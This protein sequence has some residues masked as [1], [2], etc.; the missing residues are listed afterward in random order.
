MNEQASDGVDY[1]T[2]LYGKAA[3]DLASYS[4]ECPICI[5][6][7]TSVD[8]AAQHLARWPRGYNLRD[9]QTFANPS[10]NQRSIQTKG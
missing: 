10:N 5:P 8:E 6:G 4:D 7:L 9:G 2:K 3:E 1:H